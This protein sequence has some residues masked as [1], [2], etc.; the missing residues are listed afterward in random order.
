MPWGRLEPSLSRRWKAFMC[1]MVW[2]DKKEKCWLGKVAWSEKEKD[3]VGLFS[4]DKTYHYAATREFDEMVMRGKFTYARRAHAIASGPWPHVADSIRFVNVR[5]DLR[6]KP[7]GVVRGEDV[8]SKECPLIWAR[9][10]SGEKNYTE[11]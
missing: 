1:S 8:A 11:L 7:L 5:R 6:D 10:L 4:A 9:R 3:I 2:F